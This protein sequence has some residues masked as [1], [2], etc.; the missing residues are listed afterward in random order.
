M[1]DNELGA[2]LIQIGL[3]TEI[4]GRR[5]YYLPE[6]VSTN[7]I[8]MEMALRGESEGAL[9]I[10]ETQTHGKGRLKRTWFSPPGMGLLFSLILR[11]S[12]PPMEVP[13]CTLVFGGAAARA[14]RAATGLEVSL[15]WPND[16]MLGDRKVGGLL[17]EGKISGNKMEYLVLGTGINVNNEEESFPEEIR[18]SA[19]SLKMSA[20][21][22]FPRLPLLLGILKEM[23]LAYFRFRREG[24]PRMLAE[25]KNLCLS[26]NKNL[27]VFQGE[28]RTN[29]RAVDI[30]D[31]GALVLEL[32]DGSRKEIWWADL[33]EEK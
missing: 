16:L 14:L 15:K 17:L 10:T 33:V 24:L 29:G 7:E 23:E 3:Q 11:P 6:T 18:S 9:V 21:R 28:T 8:A 27:T 4:L 22:E 12:S 31:R 25:Q 13:G 1:K 32:A 19:C 30:N 20:N 26:L 2:G 5:A